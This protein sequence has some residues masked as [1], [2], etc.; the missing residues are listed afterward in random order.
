MASGMGNKQIAEV[1]DLSDQTVKNHVSSILQKLGVSDRTQ[2]V[3]TA[4]REK[5]LPLDSE[6]RLDIVQL[7]RVALERKASDLH[8]VVGSPPALR[9]DGKLVPMDGMPPLGPST[10]SEIFKAVTTEAQRSTF[11]VEKEL[12]FAYSVPGLGRFRANAS[13]QRGS[14]SLTFRCLPPEIPSIDELGLPEILKELSLRPRGLVLV[15]GPTN[16]GKSTTLAAM[17][18]HIN[19]HAAKKVITIEDPIEYLHKNKRSL[20]T[21]RDLGDDTR[22]FASALKHALRQDPDVILVGEMRDPETAAAAITAAESGH[23]VLSTLHT[24]SAA[25]AIDRLIDLFPP[26]Q[27]EQIRGQLALVLEAIIVQILVPRAD[28]R[29]RIPAFEIMLANSAIRNLIREK[30]NYQIPSVIETSTRQ[31]MRTLTQSLAELVRRG[32]VTAEDALARCPDPNT[33]RTRI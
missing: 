1:L 22:S 9:V 13:L 3:V 30:K 24:A 26:E 6:N 8:L 29:G 20:I 28:G 5:F 14:L 21:Q 10:L 2:A 15:S 33:L 17:V 19:E 27:Q 23:L 18:N 12:D 11:S 4:I 25:D 31:G 32:L 16:S 7:L